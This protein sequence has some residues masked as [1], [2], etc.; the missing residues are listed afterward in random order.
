M[1]FYS[2]IIQDCR[3]KIHNF[4]LLLNSSHNLAFP[5]FVLCSISEIFILP[6]SLLRFSR[7]S[8][9]AHNFKYHLHIVVSHS[10]YLKPWYDMLK[11]KVT[12]SCPTLCNPMDC[13]HGILQARML[14]WVA[15]S[16]S[17]GSS[18]PRDRAQVFHIAG[19]F[20]TGWATREAQEYWSGYPIHSPADLPDPGIE[21][22]S[23]A[24]QTDS[25]PTELWGKPTI[26]HATQTYILSLL[27]EYIFTYTQHIDRHCDFS[28]CV[29]N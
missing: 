16:F 1:K 10:P 19:G 12:Q 3:R 7:P 4:A 29:K 26:W 15:F 23:P 28:T 17:R 24:L 2:V 9:H 25:L 6:T 8:L 5:H 13:I 21:P 27:P 11:V 18:Q 14:E 22:G 20:F